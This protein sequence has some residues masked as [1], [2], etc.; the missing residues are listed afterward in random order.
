MHQSLLIGQ[1]KLI[2]M[3]WP[4]NDSLSPTLLLRTCDQNDASQQLYNVCLN[5]YVIKGHFC[6][7]TTWIYRQLYTVLW[8]S[9]G[10]Q[11]KQRPPGENLWVFLQYL[12]SLNT[13]SDQLYMTQLLGCFINKDYLLSDFDSSAD[14]TALQSIYPCMNAAGAEAWMYMCHTCR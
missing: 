11:R 6:L 13:Y 3:Y 12:I 9:G 7:S 4:Q 8:F 1:S 2:D 14:Q 5:L 10:R